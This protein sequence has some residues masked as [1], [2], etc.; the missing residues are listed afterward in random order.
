MTHLPAS[1]TAP[2]SPWSRHQIKAQLQ[3]AV[4]TPIRALRPQ[5]IPLLMV[6]FAYGAM[7]LIAVAKEFWIKQ[8]LTLAPAD[9]AAIAVWLNIPWTVKM[10]F[11]EL[12]DSVPMLGSR[13]RG[14]VLIG[15]SLIAAGMV[16]LWIAAA[17]HW[18]SVSRNTLYVTAS[19]MSVVGLVLQDVT[20]DAM[21]TEV[22]A[23]VHADGSPRDKADV[24]RDLGMVQVLGRLAMAFGAFLTAGLAGWA[25]ASMSY[26]NVFLLG[27]LIPAISI[28]GALLVKLE[29]P[30][31]RA[32]DWKILGGGIAFGA[33]V[34]TM[35]LSGLAWSQEIV[36]LVSISVV[37]WMLGH[38]VEEIDADTRRKILY[39]AILIFLYRATPN[40]GPGYTW[41]S[42]DKLGFDE[43]FLGHLSQIGAGL[44]L[45]TAWLFSDAITRQPV[46]R[47]LLWLTI[48]GAFFALPGYGLTIGIHEWTDR[49][50]GLGA[51]SIALVD[52]AIT[53]PLA[54]LSMIPMLTLIAIYAP[55]GSRA[56]WFA[57]MA[58]L[59][60]LAISA[61]DLL[62]KYLNLLFP[63]ARGVYNQLPWLYATVW[64]LGLAIPLAA[65][66][67][68]G[69]RVR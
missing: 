23:R 65:I 55:K 1:A 14:Y 13:R 37:V 63:V 25:A 47:V 56:L 30:E 18:P 53:S 34:V 26:A 67:V 32:I 46:A 16:L 24:D 8:S 51:R 3:N 10:V 64:M 58:S 5:Y 2:D 66:V 31:A 4:L 50:F 6:Y 61:G 19:L 17:G 52:A 29:T 41:F 15:G 69:R 62:T 7:G 42:I 9:L 35:G 57:L 43:V 38:V 12:V 11:G 68:L 44:A 45:V 27:L 60:N 48:A 54:Q 40:V 36:F 59:M 49:L 20:A 28:S 22:V 33:F 39:A 21:S